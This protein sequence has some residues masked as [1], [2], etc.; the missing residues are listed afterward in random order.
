MTGPRW[1]APE[2]GTRWVLRLPNWI[3]DAVQVLPALRALPGEGQRYLGVA[4]P[5][6]IELYRSLSQ[7]EELLEARGS[8]APLELAAP[9]RAFAPQRALV[10][11]EA[12][13]GAVLARVSGAAARL[14]RGPFWRA[15]GLTDRLAPG[16]RDRPL[17]RQYVELAVAAGGTSAPE[18]SFALDP[19]ETAR[20]AARDLI[21]EGASPVALAPGA[22]YGSAKQWPLDR[23]QGLARALRERGENVVV[24]GSAQERPAGETLAACGARDLT[25]RTDLRGG[26]A[27]LGRCR[28]LVTNDSGAMH[29]ARA[30]GTPVVALFGSSSARWTGPEP[31][32]GIVL[33]H[34]VACSP[35]FRRRCPLQG[36]AHLLCLRGTEVAHVLRALEDLRPGGRS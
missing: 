8:R 35:C 18:P 9:L 28:V 6:V 30:A 14:G 1:S 32:E 29:M 20:A 21:P 3:G 10:F 24:V 13:S 4:H 22:A 15:P 2:P 27:V 25:G 26:I 12:M 23:F 34:A 17:W 33:H 7:F 31:H 36:D 16:T 19:G 5:R 11:T